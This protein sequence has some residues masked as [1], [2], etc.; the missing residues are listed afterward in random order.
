VNEL[1]DAW[2]L[3]VADAHYAFNDMHAMMAFVAS[4]REAARTLARRA[5]RADRDGGTNALMTRESPA[6]C[7][8]LPPSAAASGTSSSR[9]FRRCGLIAH[10]FGGSH[11]Q[12][13]ILS[14]TLIEAARAAARRT[15]PRAPAERTQVKP[16]SLFNW[17]LTA[18]RRSSCGEDAR[19]QA[20]AVADADQRVHGASRL[21]CASISENAHECQIGG[22]PNRRRSSTSNR[23]GA[24]GC[25]A[26]CCTA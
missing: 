26:C 1:A 15:R 2:E 9:C 10:R 23:A 8:R 22:T 19:R 13:D 20:Q 12:R 17:R 21:E 14:L 11:A 16:T 24:T 7:V 4:G 3:F 25:P 5:S 6:G 18:R